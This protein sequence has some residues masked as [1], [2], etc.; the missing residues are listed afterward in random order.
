MNHFIPKSYFSVWIED[1][2][3][4]ILEY[5]NCED[6][7]FTEDPNYYKDYFLFLEEEVSNVLSTIKKY[8]Y[9]SKD[10]VKIDDEILSVWIKQL[11]DIV[12]EDPK[13]FNVFKDMSTNLAKLPNLITELKTI[14]NRD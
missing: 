5:L 10:M 3:E 4:N 6:F 8:T 1:V 13:K 7:S 14:V 9:L 12:D 2:L 11:E